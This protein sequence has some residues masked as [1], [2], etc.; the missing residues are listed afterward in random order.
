MTD[1]IP[2]NLVLEGG[3]L[4]GMF[5]AGVLDALDEQNLLFEYV[6]GVSAGACMGVSY[7]SR[8]RGRSRKITL[9]YCRDSRYFSW[10]NLLR[11]GNLFGVRFTYE[12]IP[13]RLVPFDYT[14]LEQSPQRFVAVTT[15]CATG[16]AV[17]LENDTPEHKKNMTQAIRASASMPFF[18]KPVLIENRRLLDGGIAD[19]IPVE[20]ARQN[21]HTQSVVVLT[22]PKGYRKKNGG[23]LGL[24]KAF[25]PRYPQLAKAMQQR[26]ANY[27]RS[28][29]LLE[30][31]ESEGQCL[32]IYPPAHIK[33]SRL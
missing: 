18:S 9:T 22:R 5:T 15:D 25:L 4:R 7:L 26:S 3:A 12:E 29:A 10:R 30:K 32:V 11:E 33:V 27:N 2:A 20:Y 13:R 17:Y 6:I 8:Q 21:G 16:Q 14:A 31:L 24:Y 28:L 19:S 1:L 23:G